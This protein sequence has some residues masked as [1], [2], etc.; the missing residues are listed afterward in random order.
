MP[1]YSRT[2]SYH[3]HG[4]SGNRH[5]DVPARQLKTIRSEQAEPRGVTDSVTEKEKEAAT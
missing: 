5:A 2:L 1:V 4:Q 3:N